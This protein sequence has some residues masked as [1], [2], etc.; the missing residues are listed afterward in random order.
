MN[1]SIPQLSSKWQQLGEQ[2]AGQQRGSAMDILAA[3][4]NQG[5][6]GGIGNL[7]SRGMNA[8]G[9]LERAAMTSP[10]ALQASQGVTGQLAQNVAQGIQGIDL[11]YLQ[12]QDMAAAQKYAGE[13]Q[14]K[15]GIGGFISSFFGG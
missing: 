1:E 3:Q 13:K 10:S 8:G 12:G 9:S 11:P 6:Y 2:L 7:A 15:A 4:R 14:N 5:I